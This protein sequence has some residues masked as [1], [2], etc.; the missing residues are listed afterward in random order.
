M[1]MRSHYYTQRITHFVWNHLCALPFS[2]WLHAF[3]HFYQIHTDIRD[4]YFPSCLQ[5]LYHIILLMS[6]CSDVLGY[7]CNC[8]VY[9]L[10]A[11]QNRLFKSRYLC[12]HTDLP[13]LCNHVTARKICQ[14]LCY[15]SSCQRE[16]RQKVIRWAK[17]KWWQCVTL[18]LK[19]REHLQRKLPN[20]F[21]F[22]YTEIAGSEDMIV[23]A[24][25]ACRTAFPYFPFYAFAF[26]MKHGLIRHS[27]THSV[28]LH[29]YMNKRFIFLQVFSSLVSFFSSTLP[30]KQFWTK[31]YAF[32]QMG[33]I[34]QAPYNL[35]I[36]RKRND[37]KSGHPI[38]NTRTRRN[39]QPLF[40][41]QSCRDVDLFMHKTHG[42]TYLS[43][44]FLKKR[45]T[46]LMVT[47]MM[48][49]GLMRSRSLVSH[50]FSSQS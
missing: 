20:D 1:I 13:T 45:G 32:L 23:Q 8:D 35:T 34:P 4:N 12:K 29:E 38:V 49:L 28:V 44:T 50:I 16:Q 7:W 15:P 36:Q 5:I 43:Y 46:L 42:L 48:M 40:N 14:I 31:I 6:R 10:F 21:L 41:A 39:S 27:A 47:T 9:T 18:S 37:S 22:S 26:N 33:G 11:N 17:W 2:C 3:L 30:N 25:L 24:G 19:W